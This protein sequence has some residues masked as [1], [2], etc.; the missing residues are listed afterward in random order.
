MQKIF[1]KYFLILMTVTV[2]L[3]LLGNFL[4]QTYFSYSAIQQD[5]TVIM[6]NIVERMES[7]KTAIAS[8]K[9]NL[10]ENYITR[11]KALAEIIAHSPNIIYDF[12]E[13]ERLASILGV[14]EVHVTD[15]QGVL[16]WGTVP[17]YYGMDFASTPQSRPFLPALTDK[18]FALAQSPQPNGLEEKLFQY[19]GVARQD[20]PGI[21]Q[22]GVRPDVLTNALVHNKMDALVANFNM[23]QGQS[24]LLIN[25]NTGLVVADSNG[26][27][28]GQNYQ[29]LGIPEANFQL[30]DTYGRLT[31]N[32]ERL[33]T[34]FSIFDEYL[35]GVGF[36][37]SY[38]FNEQTKQSLVA[39]ASCL[40]LGFTIILG[41]FF[42]LKRIIIDDIESVNHG[43]LR[44]TKGDLNVVVKARDT[45]EFVFLSLAINNMV[46]SMKQNMAAISE[47]AAELAESNRSILSS[48]AYAR[49]I[50]NSMLPDTRPFEQAFHE[51]GV[52]WEPKDAVGGDIYWIKNFDSGVVL[53]VCDCTGHGTPGA[54]LTVLVATAL[55]SIVTSENCNDP[56][57]IMWQL[58][59]KLALALSAADNVT[60]IKDGAD[61]ALLFIA[62]NGNIHLASA[63]TRLFIC[64]GERVENIRGQRLFLGE[65]RIHTKELIKTRI[66]PVSSENKY[67]VASDGLFGQIGG[68]ENKPFGYKYFKQIVLENHA[69][70]QQEIVQ[71]IHMAFKVYMGDESRRDDIT[72]IGF[73]PK[74]EIND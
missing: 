59:Q 46:A 29:E 33:H 70:S 63:N 4:I 36:T 17:G 26:V 56:A 52:L 13:I 58:D 72:L 5:S 41:I 67:Y 3:T 24:L 21:I 48:L 65:G 12:D 54:L 71:K 53:C 51:F 62:K 22:V 18:N 68:E 32:G 39:L 28:I 60:G 25:R 44:I 7:N 37:P 6:H 66:I 20:K 43:L 11:A 9:A 10:D 57:E 23:E 73:R 14:D 31:L 1:I 50:Q 69:L 45:P 61:L 15:E 16:R 47:Q 35:L 8:V 27:F 2:T 74:R 55:E 38:L 30:T 40:L 42:L 34:F 64:N 19:I 49:R